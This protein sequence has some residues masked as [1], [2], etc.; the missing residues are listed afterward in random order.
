MKTVKIYGGQYDYEQCIGFAEDCYVE[1]GVQLY[2]MKEWNGDF[3][4]DGSPLRCENLDKDD[5]EEKINAYTEFLDNVDSLRSAA[6][7]V[8]IG[9]QGALE[10]AED[11]EEDDE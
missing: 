10:L 5:L 6:A 11:E 4:Y 9:L 7:D 3:T 1:V 2:P 8:L